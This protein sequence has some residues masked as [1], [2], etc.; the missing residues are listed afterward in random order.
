MRLSGAATPTKRGEAGRPAICTPRQTDVRTSLDEFRDFQGKRDFPDILESPSSRS[1]LFSL[2]DFT[3]FIGS[4]CPDSRPTLQLLRSGGRNKRAGQMPALWMFAHEIKN[5]E[6]LMQLQQER[7]KERGRSETGRKPSAQP[8]EPLVV[9]VVDSDDGSL[10]GVALFHSRPLIAARLFDGLPTSRC[11]DREFLRGKLLAAASRRRGLLGDAFP[12]S[13]RGASPLPD[14]HRDAEPKPGTAL[15]LREGDVV[16]A[17][18]YRLVNGECDGL[19]GT[20]VDLFGSVVTVQQLTRGSEL[21]T[22]PLLLALQDLI[23]PSAVVLRNDS[24]QRQLERDPFLKEYS[25]V[26]SGSVEGWHWLQE[27]GCTFPVDLLNSP[28][29]GRLRSPGSLVVLLLVPS[30]WYYDRRDVRRCVARLAE[31]ARVLDLHCH[32]AAFSVGALRRGR[33]RSAVC[34]D[35]SSLSLELAAAAAKANEVE[36]RMLLHQGDALQWLRR[37]LDQREAHDQCTFASAHGD[38]NRM[39][40]SVCSSAKSGQCGLLALFSVCSEAP[41]D[42]VIIDPPPPHRHG[43]LKGYT[44]E[45]QQL[46][47][48]AASVTS[49]GGRLVVVESSRFLNLQQLLNLLTVAVAAAGRSAATEMHGGPTLDCP[50]DLSSQGTAGMQWVVI[51]LG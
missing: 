39:A 45:L 47:T 4:D 17:G 22:A 51:Q 43:L 24:L 32:S 48:A 3:A 15:Q 8:L 21:L 6:E 40:G 25:A 27:G 41:Y 18:F 28:D 16:A 14:G 44:D 7:S 13:L 11:I 37:K 5:F 42:L 50:Q 20:L 10:H 29:T 9:N 31:G 34:V 35:T 33:A 36:E 2:N 23:N 49:E 26:V 1:N 46:V 19:P 38:F 12:A 30:G